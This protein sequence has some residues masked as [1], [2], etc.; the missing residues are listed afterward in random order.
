MGRGC[1]RAS[2]TLE[3]EAP[4]ETNPD[5]GQVP[6]P[7]L[8]GSGEP[9]RSGRAAYRLHFPQCTRGAGL[10]GPSDWNR[11]S[12]ARG[13]RRLPSC[14]RGR[15]RGGKGKSVPNCCHVCVRKGTWPRETAP[16]GLARPDTYTPPGVRQRAVTGT[17][18]ASWFPP[19]QTES[20][21]DGC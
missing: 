9:N 4:G 10:V 13:Q 7:T 8:L 21:K 12:S 17:L 19:P 16:P 5:L 2:E 11:A 3:K 14:A 18:C 20:P 1:S 6:P 15:V